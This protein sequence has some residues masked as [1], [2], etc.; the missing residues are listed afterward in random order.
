MTC[1]Q[2]KVAER[3]QTKA[4]NNHVKMCFWEKKSDPKNF[5]LGGSEKKGILV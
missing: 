5:Y 4:Q 1:N 3:G 2:N